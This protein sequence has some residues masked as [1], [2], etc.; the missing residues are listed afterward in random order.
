MPS[1]TEQDKSGPLCGLRRRRRRSGRPR[2]HKVT[3]VSGLKKA[4][5]PKHWPCECGL[6]TRVALE[7]LRVAGRSSVEAKSDFGGLC[8]GSTECC[9]TV[10]RSVLVIG[11]RKVAASMLFWWCRT[12]RQLQFR[13]DNLGMRRLCSWTQADRVRAGR[14][15]G[16]ESPGGA[17]T[18][19]VNQTGSN[20]IKPVVV[21]VGRMPRWLGKGVGS[22]EV[23]GLVELMRCYRAVSLPE[24][25]QGESNPIKLNQT[26]SNRGAGGDYD[27]DYDYDYER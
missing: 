13:W 9:P 15:F 23:I 20:R 25:N 5:L 4:I 3:H 18:Q 17:E 1:E 27:Y 16:M 14:G 21:G 22:A 12:T 2:S 24:D 26:K 8:H 6:T 7:T 10:W 19:R 11:S